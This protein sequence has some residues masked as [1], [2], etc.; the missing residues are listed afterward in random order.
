MAVGVDEVVFGVPHVQVKRLNRFT[1][2][3]RLGNKH[4]RAMRMLAKVATN[5]GLSAVQLAASRTRDSHNNSLRRFNLIP[6]ACSLK[7]TCMAKHQS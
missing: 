7:P 4:V 1:V 5:A 3:A 2:S 6:T